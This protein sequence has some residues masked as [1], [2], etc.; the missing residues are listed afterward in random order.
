MK[1]ELVEL[2][3]QSVRE[4]A[5]FEGR[6]LSCPL[7]PGTILFGADGILD[8]IDLVNVVILVEQYIS[9]QHGASVTLA[10]RRAL[11]QSSSPFRTVESLAAY[12]EI[13]LKEAA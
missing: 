4:V 12:A 13:L 9:D 8:S 2:V 10:D 7:G 1:K 5:D 3:I 6:E 11:S